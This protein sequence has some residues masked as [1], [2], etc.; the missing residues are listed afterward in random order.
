M[1]TTRVNKIMRSMTRVVR[2]VKEKTNRIREQER[3]RTPRT[4]VYATYADRQ[5]IS[6]QIAL[7]RQKV[8][9]S[10]IRRVMVRRR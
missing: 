8:S 9:R 5:T 1:I 2:K 4:S 3:V 10:L 7:T 6:R